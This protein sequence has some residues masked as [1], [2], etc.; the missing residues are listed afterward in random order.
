MQC[1][2]SPLSLSNRCL[3]QM[4]GLAFERN[5]AARDLEVEKKKTF[6]T[7]DDRTISSIKRAYFEDILD[8]DV[9]DIFHYC[10]NYIGVLTG[11]YYSYRTF[12]DYFTANYWQ[13][14]NCEKVLLNRLKWIAVYAAFFLTCSY[15]WPISVSLHLFSLSLFSI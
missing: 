5:S 10:F 7:D 1:T 15:F 4:V 6:S 2:Y 13:H 9:F 14:V 3:L 8:L 11:P 12:R